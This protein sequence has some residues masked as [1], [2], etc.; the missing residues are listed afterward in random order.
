MHTFLE[1][2]SAPILFLYCNTMKSY[3]TYCLEVPFRSL[4][5]LPPMLGFEPTKHDCTPEQENP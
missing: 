5:E 1:E 4:I 3:L 2:C